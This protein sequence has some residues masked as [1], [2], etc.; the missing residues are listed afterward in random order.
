MQDKSLWEAR[1]AEWRASGLTSTEFCKGKDFTPGGL[2]N[3]AHLLRRVKPRRPKARPA[4]T[5]ARVP[6]A[7]VI[8]VASPRTA[9]AARSP[10]P[11]EL[12]FGDARVRVPPGFDPRT[13]A[14]VV[15]VLRGGGRR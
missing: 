8:R 6:L 12:D 1:I 10:A 14:G 9:I 15:D 13:L 7:R 4:E 5:P 11:I 3:A 2:R